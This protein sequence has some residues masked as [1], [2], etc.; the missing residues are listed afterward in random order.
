M[1]AAPSSREPNLTL[2]K[3]KPGPRPAQ[4]KEQG[5]LGV[6]YCDEYEDHC[7]TCMP[8]FS[9]NPETVAIITV[10]VLFGA[11]IVLFGR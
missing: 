10:L 11:Y 1:R 2:S 5:M 3:P 6:H 9:H 7:N 8:S 4:H